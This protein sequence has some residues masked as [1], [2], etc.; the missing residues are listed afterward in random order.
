MLLETIII[1]LLGILAGVFTGLI[2]GIHNNMIA[3]I[4]LLNAGI[5]LLFF[6]LNDLIIFIICVGL[7]HSFTSFI[8][9]ILFGVPSEDSSMS[10]LPAH[11]LVLKGKAYEAIF[12]SS[13]GSL[14][15][16][17]FAFFI[18]IIAY[19]YLENAYNLA[20]NYIAYFLIFVV[21]LL[22]LLEEDINKRFWAFIVVLFS[23]GFGFLI[24]N[25]FH[26][27]NSLLLLFSG[28]FGVSGIIMSILSEN[29]KIPKQN[30]KLDF[31]Y[32]KKFFISIINGTF[33]A[34]ICS[35][36]PGLGNAQAASISS[37]FSKNSS[38]KDF[39]I[40]SSA[41][42]TINFILSFISLYV[43]EKARNGS[44]LVISLLIEKI[45][46]YEM[47]FYFSIIFFVSIL[48]FLITLFL[49]KILI[50]QISKINVKKLN[51][52]VLIFIFFIC[53]IFD[54]FFGL[55]ILVCAA[56]LGLFCL[57]IGVRRVHMMAVL[58]VPVVFNLI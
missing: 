36:S 44:V 2:P 11:Q 30:F 15:G 52:F 28:L 35:I 9:A 57:N 50:I 23:G 34:S 33:S 58:L 25:S 45:E 21:L 43:I 3:Q 32:N 53:F 37:L 40:I 10:I 17:F 49:G 41:I 8:P 55:I 39:I 13:I 5:L 48:A 46:F 54:G 4:V 1:I 27:E 51:I 19:F 29:S 26:I 7:V 20:K 22:I 18:V 12:L 42:N 38:G 6:S 14:F 56:S 24:L 16:M 31:K 47:I